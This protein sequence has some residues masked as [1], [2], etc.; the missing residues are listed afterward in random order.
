MMTTHA[1][2]ITAVCSVKDD[3]I[4]WIFSIFAMGLGVLKRFLFEDTHPFQR[5]GS[6][7][8]KGTRDCVLVIDA[9]GSMLGD[10]WKPSRL[11]AAKKSAKTFAKRLSQEQPNACIGAVVFGCEARVICRLTAA[12]EFGKISRQIDQIDAGGSTNMYAGLKAAFKLL[13]DH[14]QVC[15]V[16]L[17]TDGRNT[18]KNPENLAKKLKEFT[19]IECVGIGGSPDDVDEALLKKI[20]SSYPDG[21]KRYRWIG[22]KEQLIK[23]FHNLAGAIRR[24]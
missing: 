19:T 16:V 7:P 18:Q 14:G 22:Q 1:K 8:A 3:S 6:T 23:H 21:K 10:D 13:K 2:T 24:A 9:S 20:A 11:D 4:K 15:Q 5:Q 17:L 12:K